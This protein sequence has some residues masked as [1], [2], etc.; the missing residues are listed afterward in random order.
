[1]I[2]DSYLNE[3]FFGVVT[4]NDYGISSQLVR[5][6]QYHD[7]DDSTPDQGSLHEAVYEELPFVT[8]TITDGGDGAGVWTEMY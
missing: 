1:M 3:G 2:D 6:P 8:K 7:W 4:T 5:L